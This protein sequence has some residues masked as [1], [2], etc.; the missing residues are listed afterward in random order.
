MFSRISQL[1]K[2]ISDEFESV[3]KP[4]NRSPGPSSPEKGGEDFDKG[5]GSG[6]RTGG[7]ARR[8]FLFAPKERSV[9]SPVSQNDFMLRSPLVFDLEPLREMGK[10]LNQS[11]HDLDIAAMDNASISAFEQGSEE[12]VIAMDS[13]VQS[14][15][16]EVADHSDDD[17][18]ISKSIASKLRK[19]N[20]YE[21]KYPGEPF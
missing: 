13:K 7:P 3:V 19:F 14:S 8:K 2:N 15:K 10:Q 21:E 20:K 5:G 11:S 1:G 18:P 9:S 12:Q 4:N 6:S 17:I 16:S